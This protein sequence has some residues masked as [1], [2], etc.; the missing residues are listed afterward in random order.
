MPLAPSD[1]VLQEVPNTIVE[2]V[3]YTEVQELRREDLDEEVP[4]ATKV[5]RPC[6]LGNGNVA[7]LFFF[8]SIKLQSKNMST[9]LIDDKDNLLVGIMLNECL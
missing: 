1:T 8:F 3:T 7:F 9:Y 5:R 6:T 4:S 2:E